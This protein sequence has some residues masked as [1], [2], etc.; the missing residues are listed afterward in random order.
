MQ[1]DKIQGV[2]VPSLDWEITDVLDDIIM[3][4]FVDV[5][6]TGEYL[7]RNG[8]FI[9]IDPVKQLWRVGRV[10]TSGPKCSEK[11]EKGTY[12]LFPNDKGIQVPQVGGYK[13]VAFINEDRIFGICKPTEEQ[14]KRLE[15]QNN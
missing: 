7:Q 8:I 13:N 12:V 3:V 11:I 14:V 9:K 4:Q 15:E 10:I 2:E 6:N 5:D 1:L